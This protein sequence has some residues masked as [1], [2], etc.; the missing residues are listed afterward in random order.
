[1]NTKQRILG[2]KIAEKL[3][4]HPDYARTLGVSII[5]RSNKSKGEL[6]HESPCESR[7]ED[8]RGSHRMAM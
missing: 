6:V 3:G 1:M 8:V 2:I 7:C 4:K 5:I